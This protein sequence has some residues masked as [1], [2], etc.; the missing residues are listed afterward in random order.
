VRRTSLKGSTGKR[1]RVAI[2]AERLTGHPPRGGGGGRPRGAPPPPPPPRGVVAVA[3][4]HPL[5]PASGGRSRVERLTP[6]WGYAA[7]QRPSTPASGSLYL[8]AAL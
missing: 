4:R 1:L 3:A 6:L 2:M 5:D 8:V 7:G